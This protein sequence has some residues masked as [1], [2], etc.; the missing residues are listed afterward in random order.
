MLKYGSW[1]YDGFKLD[2]DFYDGQ[3]NVDLS[4]YIVDNEW[5]LIQSSGRKNV[6]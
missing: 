2:L 5:S 6:K 1:T 3:E 4:D